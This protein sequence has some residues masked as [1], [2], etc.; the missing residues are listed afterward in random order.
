MRNL[1]HT[2]IQGKEHRGSVVTARTPSGKPIT[3]LREQGMCQQQPL[4]HSQPALTTLASYW[5]VV[6]SEV[7]FEGSRYVATTAISISP[8]VG[9]E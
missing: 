3:R 5:P 4:Y 6:L 9:Q 1:S 2:F 7:R 8:R